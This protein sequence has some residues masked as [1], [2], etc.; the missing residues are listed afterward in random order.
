MSRP[1]RPTM[2]WPPPL[3]GRVRWA[4]LLGTRGRGWRLRSLLRLLDGK[5][6]PGATVVS[7]GSGPGFDAAR[8]ARRLGP[9][10]V[11]WVLLDPQRAMWADPRPIDRAAGR[12]LH[13]ERIQGDAAD[14]PLGTASADVVLSIGALC[15]MSDAAVPRAVAETGRVL[16]PG[17]FLLFAVP[18]RRGELD[19]ARW[20]AAGFARRAGTRPGRGLFQKPL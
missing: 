14:L 2:V 17:G 8:L 5:V 18:R 10:P 9:I 12:A 6:P 4:W 15:C 13:P 1:V 20:S 3:P 16:K 11:R 7:V 19:E